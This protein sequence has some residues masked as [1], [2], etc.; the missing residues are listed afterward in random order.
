MPAAK[1]KT[2]NP[3]PDKRTVST[4]KNC[5]IVTEGAKNGMN[6]ITLC[7]KLGI[8]KQ[9]MV[10]GSV[11]G[12]AYQK[13]RD[14]LGERITMESIE[15][16]DYRDRALIINKM[17]LFS[18][19]IEIAKN[20]KDI[21]TL[22]EAQAQM[23]EAYAAGRLSPEQMSG[24]VKASS[25]YGQQLFDADIQTRMAELEEQMAKMAK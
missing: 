15:S 8:H 11:L 4:K 9:S 7:R 16:G 17:S 20:I 13:G 1:T 12:D 2:K 3:S 18:E 24:W 14:A 19:P 21:P 23:L 25:S 10:P 5:K 6:K 22:L